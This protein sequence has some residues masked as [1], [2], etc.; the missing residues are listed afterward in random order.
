MAE[1][2]MGAKRAGEVVLGQHSYQS[3][4]AMLRTQ[5]WVLIQT[6]C[7]METANSKQQLGKCVQSVFFLSG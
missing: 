1:R 7:N 4:G 2:A 6:A 5:L 3:Q